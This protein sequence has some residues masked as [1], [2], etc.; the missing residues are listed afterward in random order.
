MLN[1]LPKPHA[2]AVRRRYAARLAAAAALAIGAGAA[3]HALALVPAVVE[4]RRAAESLAVRAEALRASAETREYGEAAREASALRRA[5]R[6]ASVTDDPAL[7]AAADGVIRAVPGGV[8]IATFAFDRVGSS[9]VAAQVTG[10]ADTRDALLLFRAN[11]EAAPG[12]TAVDV[13][14][15]ALASERDAAFTVSVSVDANAI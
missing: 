11:L 14:V 4:G 10:L 7:S 1:L 9:T 2:R 5:A 15:S 8:S 3:A 12:V 13:P 6:A